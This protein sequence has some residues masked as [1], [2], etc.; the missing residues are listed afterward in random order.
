MK[1][2]RFYAVT[3]PPRNG[4]HPRRER[5]QVVSFGRLT[6]V[7]EIKM[8]AWGF[9]RYY[10]EPTPKELEGYELVRVEVKICETDRA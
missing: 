2:I 4:T 9:I 6:Y 3:H 8:E 7:P 1:E 5:Q 10:V